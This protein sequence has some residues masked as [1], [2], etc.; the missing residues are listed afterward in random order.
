[1]KALRLTTA[2]LALATASV[3]LCGCSE[4]K[5]E[6]NYDMLGGETTN[7]DTNY[8]V[9][10]RKDTTSTDS[11][12]EESTTS[13]APAAQP[14]TTSKP[15]TGSKPDTTSKPEATSQPDTTQKPEDTKPSD[16]TEK[17]DTASKPD[18]TS[19]PDTTSKP[20][21]TQKFDQNGFPANPKPM[22]EFQDASGQWWDYS[23]IFGWGKFDPNVPAVTVEE[24]PDFEVEGGDTQILF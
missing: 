14:D 6:Y 19:Q 8:D 7:S 1:M 5:P 20:D 13:T 22:Q 24:F 12:A 18:T 23:P 16:T 4:N 9:D 11:S 15:D 17:E 3:L 21:T 10:I 2:A